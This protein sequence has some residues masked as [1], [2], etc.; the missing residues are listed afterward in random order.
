MGFMLSAGVNVSEYDLSTVVPGVATTDAALAGIFQWGPV[1]ER[2]LVSSETKLKNV[3]GPPN[4]NNAETWFTGANF[5]SYGSSLHVVRAAN[6]TSA[7]ASVGA[8]N[9]YANTNTVTGVVAIKTRTDFDENSGSLDGDIIYAAKWPGAIGNSLKISQCDSVAAFS[10]NL[11]CAGTDATQNLDVSAEFTMAI[12]NTQL[13][14]AVTPGDTGSAADAN[15]YAHALVANLSVGDII[16]VGN[17]TIGHQ[18]A[19]IKTISSVTSNSSGGYAT[20]TTIDPYRLATAFVA[21]STVNDTIQRQWEYFNHVSSAP[22]TSFYADSIGST[23]VDTMHVVVVDEDGK[24]TGVPGAILETFEHV[25]RATDAKTVDGAANYFKTV[26]NNG[27]EYIWAVN[28]RSGAASAVAASIVTSTNLSAMTKSLANGTDG[29]TEST[30]PLSIVAAG[31]D[32]FNAADVDISLILQGKP[33]GGTSGTSSAVSWQLAN[34][35]IDNI[36]EV[37]KDCV[38]FTS[39]DDSVITT[40]RGN[41]ALAAVE[42]ASLIHSS[43]YAVLDSG[44]KYQY[45]KYNDVYRW[46]PLNG[47]IAGLCARTDDQRD[48]WWSPAGFNRG[49][50]KNLVKLRWNPGTRADRD[51][52]YKNNINPVVTF[53]G[54]G[55]F[56]YGDKTLNGKSSAFD[57]INVRRLFIVLEKAIATASK[58]LL[59]EFNDEFTRAQ[60]RNMVNPYLRDIQGRRGI[61][62]FLVVCDETN[63]T[64]ERIDRSEFWGDI[65]IKPARS[66]NFIQLNF[67][68]VR[69]GVQFSEVVGQY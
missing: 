44:Y 14:L 68:A 65:Y 16:T 56:L 41:E 29:Y 47:D 53:A 66:I 57:H 38:V 64:A 50:I 62:D 39:I 2:V 69:T 48:P 3:F 45:D 36:A 60:F 9:A 23:A 1:G 11:Y 4:S 49:Q 43:S 6:T 12:G 31:Y 26:I 35:L 20:I 30:V 61:T 27:S 46:V 59:F 67:I 22:Q 10:S 17:T 55:T 54:Q 15:T 58:L 42:W 34:Y 21:N 8:L 52:L 7:S 18:F 51:T 37:R 25:S 40:N 13:L 5:L 24:F 32:V 63:N 33:I 19:K 28:D